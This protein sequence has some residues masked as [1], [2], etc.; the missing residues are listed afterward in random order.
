MKALQS[1]TQ[2]MGHGTVSSMQASSA[3]IR[4]LE[5]GMTGNIRAAERFI[6]LIPGVGKALQAA[7]PVV[8]GIALAG[9]FVKIGEEAAKAIKKVEEA[10]QSITNSFR[11]LNNAAQSSNDALAIT[12]DKLENEIAKLQGKPQNNLKLAIDEARLAADK[13]AE[14]LDRDNSKIKELLSHNAVPWWA[15]FLGKAGTSV[16]SDAINQQNQH[17]ADLANQANVLQHQGDQAGADRTRAQI[18]STRQ[19]YLR[20]NAADITARQANQN[21]P[22][23]LNQGANVSALTGQ[24]SSL[25]NQIDEQTQLKRNVADQATKEQL[26]AAKAMSEAQ[27]KV[28]EL[29]LKQDEE[30]FKKQDAFN[31]MSINE[32]I[33]FWTAKIRAFTS[34]GEQFIA[35]QDKIY[36]L[37]SKRP[38]L[39]TENKKNQ[40]EVGKSQ[41]E[42]SDLLGT[43]NKS[44]TALAIEQME[45]AT[46]STEKYYEIVAQGTAEKVK[47]AQAFQESSIKIALEQGT[48]SKL[49]A[50]QAMAAI[51]AKDHV[52]ALANVN[53]ELAEQIALI[54]SAKMSPQ[55]QADA[56]RNATEEAGNKGTQIQA[57]GQI[58]AAQDQQAIS[59]LQIGPGVTQALGRMANDWTNMTAEIVQVMTRAA[60]GLN[61]D[62]VKLAT[63]QYKKGD[64]GKTLLGAGQGLLKTGL[65]GA[66]GSLLKAFHLGGGAKGSLLKAFHLG[67]GAEADGSKNNPYYVV[68]AS[69]T[70]APASASGGAGGAIGAAGSAAAPLLGGLIGKIAPFVVPFFAGGGD[71]LAN[72]PGIVG[73][74]GPELFMPRS[75]G[76]IIPNHQLGGAGDNHFHFNIQG[77]SDPAAVHAAIMRAAPHIVAAAVQTQ[78]L[79][80]RRAPQAR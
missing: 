55:D 49:A 14:S 25:F 59:A 27:K 78:H 76:T 16:V 8:G 70:G 73:E 1:A 39:F 57:Q 68:M 32:Q 60:D 53:R 52:D 40:G 75:A 30:A 43:A 29:V 80:A 62:L 74:N 79:S 47:E 63:G 56:I 33:S 19:A 35:V 67:G 26:D 12:N 23:G 42:G 54:N 69:G 36:D 4:A 13:M 50:A 28:Q 10:P 7:F 46:K 44:L 61:N 58:Q 18:D 34:G 17:M 37:I 71:I 38:D 11:E 48:I 3:A 21:L 5:G 24:Q 64:V 31:K 72:H 6:S 51:H 20:D 9:I 15:G 41:V 77:N 2:A 22:G 66:E 45:R 65:Q